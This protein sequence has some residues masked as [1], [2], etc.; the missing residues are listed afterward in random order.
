MAASLNVFK[1]ALISLFP[2]FGLDF[3]FHLFSSVWLVKMWA[4]HMPGPGGC[5]WGFLFQ[6]TFC[7]DIVPGKY[8]NSQYLTPVLCPMKNSDQVEE[9]TDKC[10][11]EGSYTFSDISHICVH[12]YFYISVYFHIS[13]WQL[14]CCNWCMQLNFGQAYSQAHPLCF[15][16]T[17]LD[18]LQPPSICG[19]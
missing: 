15:S 12:L 13:V 6:I 7:L 16:L 17:L 11:G 1:P 5:F 9:S 8:V 18:K 4:K 19:K 14:E 10:L 3:N 2:P